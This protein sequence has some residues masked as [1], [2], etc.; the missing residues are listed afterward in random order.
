MLQNEQVAKAMSTKLTAD[1]TIVTLSKLAQSYT[2]GT[3]TTPK[4][5][6]YKAFIEYAYW[7][8]SPPATRRPKLFKDFV[9]KHGISYQAAQ[10]WKKGKLFWSLC[11]EIEK[12][13]ADGMLPA[14]F[15]GMEKGL[16][17]GDVA[18]FRL[19]REFYDPEYK[20]EQLKQKQKEKPHSITININKEIEA[21]NKD[22]SMIVDA[23]LV[24]EA[25]KIAEVSESE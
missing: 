12:H 6:Q 25:K 8:C 19:Y 5:D 16:K 11:K 10:N 2:S 4:P 17:K 1:K 24:E 3:S 15:E 22:A 23:E 9:E 21:L 13:I 14:W 7:V 20:E 18:M